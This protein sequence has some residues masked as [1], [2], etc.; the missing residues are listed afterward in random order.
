MSAVCLWDEEIVAEVPFLQLSL[1]KIYADCK[2]AI[3]LSANKMRIQ[4]I[5]KWFTDYLWCQMRHQ[6]RRLTSL[7]SWSSSSVEK[8]VWRALAPISNASRA[9]LTLINAALFEGFAFKCSRLCFGFSLKHV[10]VALQCSDCL[11]YQHF[12]TVFWWFPPFFILSKLHLNW[13][14]FEHLQA[15][16][17]F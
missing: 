2:T 6:A 10:V 14:T 1:E 17:L 15:Y 4:A 13:W 16:S 11:F 7:K 9:V 12:F 8:S 5:L 3:C